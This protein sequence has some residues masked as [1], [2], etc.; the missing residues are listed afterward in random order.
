MIHQQIMDERS[1]SIDLLMLGQ[2]KKKKGD[3]TVGGGCL[4]AVS[5]KLCRTGA[6]VLV[7]DIRPSEFPAKSML[8]AA[9]T[10]KP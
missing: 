5:P 3:C 7:I 1:F 4:G 2:K 10:S 8:T 6:E 9:I